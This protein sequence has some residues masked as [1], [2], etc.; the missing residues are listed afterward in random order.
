MITINGDKLKFNIQRRSGSNIGLFN[1]EAVLGETQ[2]SDLQE[3]KSLLSQIS[4]VR[5]SLFIDLRRQIFQI[6]LNL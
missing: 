1:V 6:C 5:I 2:R 4:F 3:Q